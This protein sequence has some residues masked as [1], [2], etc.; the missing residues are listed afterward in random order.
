MWGNVLLV[1]RITNQAKSF[2]GL[3]YLAIFK[4]TGACS[5][6]LGKGERSTS[7][8]EIPHAGEAKEGIKKSNTFLLNTR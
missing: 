3:D 5:R 7:K 4:P 2:A 1:L 6:M 8:Y